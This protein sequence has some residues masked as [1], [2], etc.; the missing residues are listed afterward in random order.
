MQDQIRL[1][2]IY[3]TFK[4]RL[5][6]SSSNK[7]SIFS[8]FLISSY[9][10]TQTAEDLS[11]LELLPDSQSQ[12]IAEKLGVQTG[13][14][15]N[16]EVIMDSFDDPSFDSMVSKTILSES[17]PEELISSDQDTLSYFGQNLFKSSAS[18]FAP[19]DLAP[20][21]LDYILGP[22]DEIRVQL[23]G[24]VTISRAIKVNREGN[25]VIPEL[26][27]IQASGIRCEI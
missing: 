3:R 26:G 19:I 16:D 18:T 17:K 23:F 21:P 15:I 12:S 10:F 4:A 1:G 25:I 6:M 9:L 14:P 7:I 5:I 2:C 27:V 13:K 11:Y 8:F 24:N 20:A 22:G